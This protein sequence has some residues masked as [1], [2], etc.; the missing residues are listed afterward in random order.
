[1]R[2]WT[3]T[4]LTCLSLALGSFGAMAQE[5]QRP[6][7]SLKTSLQG[8]ELIGEWELSSMPAT[9]NSASLRAAALAAPTGVKSGST[10]QF[11]VKLVDPNGVV[12]D[13]TGSNKLRY[14]PKGCLAFTPDGKATVSKTSTPPWSCSKGDPVML[15]IIYADDV[16]KQAAVN[17]YV[18]TIE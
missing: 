10:V 7:W 5:D 15:S 6:T 14:M 12:T 9:S 4:S 3:L 2:R 18:L 1:M 17:M 13:V 8:K 11:R 16:T